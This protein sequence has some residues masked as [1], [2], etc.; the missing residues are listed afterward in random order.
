M[1]GLLWFL[2]GVAE[3]EMVVGVFSSSSDAPDKEL[4]VVGRA[5]DL[6]FSEVNADATILPDHNVTARLASSGLCRRS[7][8]FLD[9]LEG[10]AGYLGGGCAEATDAVAHAALVNQRAHLTWSPLHTSITDRYTLTSLSGLGV[11]TIAQAMYDVLT[12]FDWIRIA[13]VY[14]PADIESAKLFNAFVAIV[15]SSRNVEIDFVWVVDSLNNISWAGVVSSLPTVI[16]SSPNT[17]VIVSFVGASSVSASVFEAMN[18]TQSVDGRALED[19]VWVSNSKVIAGLVPTT[20]ICDQLNLVVIDETGFVASPPIGAKLARLNEFEAKWN[21]FFPGFEL[22]IEARTTVAAV[23]AYDAARVLALALDAA[24]STDGQAVTSALRSLNVT[25]VVTGPWW[26]YNIDVEGGARDVAVNVWVVTS[27]NLTLAMQ[28]RPGGQ[29][30]TVDSTSLSLLPSDTFAPE[31]PILGYDP[32]IGSFIWDLSPLFGGTAVAVYVRQSL[33]NETSEI[34]LAADVIELFVPEDDRFLVKSELGIIV[35][36]CATVKVETERGGNSTWSREDCVLCPTGLEPS[37]EAGDECELCPPGKAGVSV[38]CVDCD[39]GSYSN[40]SGATSCTLCADD[41]FQPKRGQTSCKQCPNNAERFVL[42]DT[43]TATDLLLFNNITDCSCVPGFFPSVAN[44]T[45][46]DC[47]SCPRGGVCEGHTA[48]PFNK[49]GFWGEPSDD[50]TFYECETGRCRRNFKCRFGFKGRLCDKVDDGKVFLIDGQKMRCPRKV[51]Q[52]WLVFSLVLGFVL[53]LW[54]TLNLVICSN[55]AVVDAA[56]RVFQLIAIIFHNFDVPWP[57]SY[58]LPLAAPLSVL[59]FDVDIVGPTCVIKYNNGDK[60]PAQLVFLLVVVCMYAGPVVFEAARFIAKQPSLLAESKLGAL[61]FHHYRGVVGAQLST[62]VSRCCSF[63]AVQYATVSVA[64]LTSLSCRS[65]E[66]H[67]SVMTVDPTIE[68]GSPRHIG[69]TLLASLVL[70]AYTI[71]FPLAIVVALRRERRRSSGLHREHVLARFGLYFDAFL[72]H[73]TTWW[74]FLTARTLIMIFIGVQIRTASVQITAAIIVMLVSLVVH[75]KINPYKH[76]RVALVELALICLAIM[77]LISGYLI[78]INGNRKDSVNAMLL[79]CFGIGAAL[80]VFLAVDEYLDMRRKA[81][82][83]L[84]LDAYARFPTGFP[85]PYM[86]SNRALRTTSTSP[87]DVGDSDDD[88]E[89]SAASMGRDA[90]VKDRLREL[91]NTFESSV[92]TP[93]LYSLAPL[94]DANAIHANTGGELW[95]VESVASD[96]NVFVRNASPVSCYSKDDRSKF[97]RSLAESIP[98]IIDFVALELTEN[99]RK[100]FYA[101]LVDLQRHTVASRRQALFQ[102]PSLL[103]DMVSPDDRGSVL[104]GLCAANELAWRSLGAFIVQLVKA[105]HPGLEGQISTPRSLKES[106]KG[107]RKRRH[108]HSASA[109]HTLDARED[110]TIQVVNHH[111]DH[112]TF[113]DG[114]AF[115][116]SVAFDDDNTRKCDNDESR[117]VNPQLKSANSEDTVATDDEPPPL[118]GFVGLT[119]ARSGLTSVRSGLTSAPSGISDTFSVGLARG[120]SGISDTV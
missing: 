82:A 78:L 108:S 29:L 115:K 37:D 80:V 74:C 66:P 63:I 44:A 46:V 81:K 16:A 104:Y 60:L 49:A 53:V 6:A 48:A 76:P 90:D 113:K 55:F 18:C 101:V 7:D 13:A 89:R 15:A 114:A 72:T 75:V 95:S 86:T 61:L 67:G 22:D 31:A 118:G 116:P 3:G 56:L 36:R 45:G 5:V 111:L 70:A 107:H 105:A 98:G 64:A 20:Q 94:A 35:V 91:P 54:F 21:A 87:R 85:L 9:A 88:D 93:F 2:A 26:S 11:E 24:N 103:D 43:L 83:L 30:V 110:R 100:V 17:R 57:A 8:V 65:L 106:L 47:R 10:V 84:W 51:W 120:H 25:G 50:P 38:F 102:S 109:S 59:L 117:R 52:S 1:V 69:Y 12:A 79:V 32:V 97:W 68:C 27:S 40:E 92:L 33:G 73:H 39:A 19:Y 96:L 4:E 23:Y 34:K 62:A 99:R 58:T 77:T 119:S 41:Q 28:Q 112:T 42:D 71:G 14:E